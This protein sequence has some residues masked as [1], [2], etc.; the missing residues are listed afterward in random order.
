VVDCSELLRTDRAPEWNGRGG[1]WRWIA[2]N[3]GGG[4]TGKIY[5]LNDTQFSDDGV[6]ISSYYTTHFFPERAVESS[7]GLGAHR[8]LFSYLTMYVE[9]AGNLALTS[10]VDSE[11]AATAQQPLG[12]SSPGLKDL[13]CRLMCWGAGGV[14]GGYESGGC[15]VQGA[16]IY[17]VV[18]VDPWAPV[19][20][21]KLRRSRGQWSL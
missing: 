10:F 13:S 15:M 2:R 21:L 17:A 4:A 12:M 18:K 19:R 11:S 20:G 14:S 3:G 8:K 1:V 16:E 9:G 6:A 7:L 5:Q